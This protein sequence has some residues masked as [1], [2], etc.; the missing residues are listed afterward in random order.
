LRFAYEACL[1][2][3]AARDQLLYGDI[4]AEFAALSANVTETANPV[5]ITVKGQ[6]GIGHDAEDVGQEERDVLSARGDCVRGPGRVA[7]RRSGESHLPRAPE[8]PG[9]HG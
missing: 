5:V 7:L 9:V 1:R 4:T 6:L 8:A 2:D 3:A